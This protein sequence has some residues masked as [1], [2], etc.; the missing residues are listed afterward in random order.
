MTW[1]CIHR[2]RAATAVTQTLFKTYY[3]VEL[4]IFFKY[5]SSLQRDGT[6][7]ILEELSDPDGAM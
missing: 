6:V 4:Q 3:I 2:T 7:Q 5:S 1:V